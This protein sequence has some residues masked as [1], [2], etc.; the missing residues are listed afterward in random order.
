MK[1]N[2]RKRTV[3]PGIVLALIAVSLWPRQPI[4]TQAATLQAPQMARVGTPMF[5]RDP[6]W[7]QVPAK[8]RIGNVSTATAD[9]QNHIWIIHRPR[10]LPED[11][12]AMAAPP[13]IEFDYAGN[14]VQAWGGEG[15]G[16]EWPL[17]EH[18]LHVDHKGFVWVLGSDKRDGQILKFTRDGKLVMQIGGRDKVGD[19]NSQYL[20]RPAGLDVYPKT[21]ELFVSDGYGNRRVIV[22]DADTGAYK[23]HWGAYGRKPVDIGAPKFDPADPWRGYAE[24]LQQFD[25]VHDVAVSNDGL[26]YVADRGH[27]RVQV[28]T[29]EGKY[30]AQQFVG[31]DSL[32]YLQARSVAF[33]ADPQQMFLYVAGNPSIFILN[34]KT[35][36]IVGSVETGEVQR[37]PPN[38]Q[39]GADGKGN[40]YTVQAAVTGADGKSGGVGVQRFVFKGLS[41]SSSFDD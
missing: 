25:T 12:R 24:H 21:N 32:E 39:I 27:K 11:Q 17:N 13:V 31:V 4:S 26:V 28:F 9:A 2:M 29:L 3:L 5:E 33:S 8:W 22:F 30:I 23:R 16:Y 15:K 10:T 6:S 36:E 7:P 20:N 18:G 37:H 34:R 40:I 19:S 14:V 41:G 38:H 1:S 35:L